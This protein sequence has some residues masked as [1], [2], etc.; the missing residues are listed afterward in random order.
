MSRPTPSHYLRKSLFRV[1]IIAII[2]FP[3]IN[4]V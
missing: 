1:Y 2:H 3:I 4:H